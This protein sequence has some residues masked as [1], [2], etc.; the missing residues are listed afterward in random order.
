M[1]LLASSL[2]THAAWHNLT[3]EITHI[4][5]YA[6]TDTVLVK[7]EGPGIPVDACSSKDYFAIDGTTPE[8]RRSQMI[9]ALLSEKTAGTKDTIAYDFTSFCVP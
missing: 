5:F 3:G 6:T 4:N 2:N 7:L 8:A 1:L 9:A